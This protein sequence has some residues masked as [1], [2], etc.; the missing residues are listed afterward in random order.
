MMPPVSK[1][2]K[3]RRRVVLNTIQV[4]LGMFPTI[5]RPLWERGSTTKEVHRILAEPEAHTVIYDSVWEMSLKPLSHA[6]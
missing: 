4:G 2:F 5:K 1:I 6:V 3:G